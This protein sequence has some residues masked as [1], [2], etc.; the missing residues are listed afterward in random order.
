MATY[1]SYRFWLLGSFVYEQMT[2]VRPELGLDVAF[3]Y[4][5]SAERLKGVSPEHVLDDLHSFA[6]REPDL[7][8]ELAHP[9]ISREHGGAFLSRAD[10]IVPPAYLAGWWIDC[11]AIITGYSRAQRHAS[12]RVPHGAV[13]GLDVLS[14]GA[15]D[16]GRG[17]HYDED[18]SAQHRF[19]RL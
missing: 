15:R 7:V 18:A 14:E 11:G 16:V 12:V 6:A 9:D 3:V 5:R 19:F 1:W 10:S 4:N 8:V 17:I 13:I 2:A